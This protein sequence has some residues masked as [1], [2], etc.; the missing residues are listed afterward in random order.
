MNVTLEVTYCTTKGIRTTFHSEGMEAEKAITI[1]EDFQRTGRIKQIVFRDERDSPWTLKELKRF[2]EEVKTEPHHLSVYFDGG[3][4]LETQRS[5]LGCVI[6]YEQND[7]NYRV[8][9]N[10]TVAS[11]TSNNEAEYAALHL[12]LKE[13]EGIGA[14]HLPITIYGDS[15]VVINQLKGEWACM[16]EMLN[17]WADRIDQHLAKLG[18]TATYKLIPR[19]ENRE[20]DQ[21]ATQALNG[22]EI[23]SQRD[24][25]ERGAD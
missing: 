11:L 18:M 17:K 4:D 19:K 10:A 1:A 22:Q 14:H 8:R 7:T 21:L 16:E 23:I 2:L 9:R 24:V 6:Y 12:G 25:S 15:Q 3:F 13:L 20:A 5:G